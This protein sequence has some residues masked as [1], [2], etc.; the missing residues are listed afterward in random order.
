M[1]LNIYV[2]RDERF[3]HLKMADFLGYALKS[4]SQFIEPALEAVFDSTPKEFDSIDEVYKL[5]DEGIQLPKGHFLDDI[6][7]NIPLEMLKEIFPTNNDNLFEF[8]TPQVIQGNVSV[9]YQAKYLL[10][11]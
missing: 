11:I 9:C 1:S 3:G 4:I 5:Y 6:R 8:P 10:A 2:P 7:K